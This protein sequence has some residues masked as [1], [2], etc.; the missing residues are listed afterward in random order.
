MISNLSDNKIIND[1]NSNEKPTKL[2]VVF[3]R[4]S[5]MIPKLNTIP[6]LLLIES[7]TLTFTSASIVSF[8]T[9]RWFGACMHCDYNLRHF[10]TM[11]SMRYIFFSPMSSILAC[12]CTA[13]SHVRFWSSVCAHTH[14]FIISTTTKHRFEWN[15]VT[16]TLKY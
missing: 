2:D 15:N 4:I 11:Y 3:G 1:G 14:T 16:F 9:L 6:F 10:F 12:I 13:L 5:A 7:T 8:F